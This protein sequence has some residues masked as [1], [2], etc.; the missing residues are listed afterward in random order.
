VADD[1]A[2]F[3][4]SPEDLL[5]GVRAL[6][7]GSKL[8]NED[9]LHIL[10]RAG[11]AGAKGLTKS[12][13]ALFKTRWVIK[14]EAEAL[15]GL[16]LAL[17]TLIPVQVLEQELL[18]F[19]AVPEDGAVQLL[20]LHRAAPPDL[21][22]EEARKTFRR[23]AQVGL[24]VYSS[25]YKTVRAV[26]PPPDELRAGELRTLAAMISPKT[27]FSNLAR[28]RRILRGLKGTVWWADKHFGARALEEL[29]E[30]I[31]S[32]RV[33]EIRIVSGSAPNVLTAKSLKDFKRF[34]NEM[35]Q[36]G[37]KAE[38]RVDDPA[39]DWHDRWLVD[40]EGA[41]NVPPVNSLFKNDYSEML[42][43]DARPPLED[44]WNRSTPRQ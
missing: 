17:R 43:T 7:N 41:W 4:T 22:I 37:L 12:G 33:K 38:W 36:K 14:D 44:W 18:Q 2:I 5:A 10:C 31:D 27:P 30:E 8:E 6:G 35:L 32:E 24:A 13:E 15:R 3:I 20:R 34:Q 16:G 11:L 21:T 39:T 19:G 1:S 26:V 25:K 40:D 23:L 42:P 9:V 28:L 29:A